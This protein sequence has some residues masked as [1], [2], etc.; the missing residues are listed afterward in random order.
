MTKRIYGAVVRRSTDDGFWAEVPDL[1][2]CFG[3]GATFMEAVESVR[4]GI[5]THLAALAEHQLDIPEATEV[6]AA[7]GKVVYLLVEPFPSL[8]EP[9]VSAAEAARRLGVSPARVSQ[10]IKAGKLAARRSP[11]G[12]LVALASVEEY[13]RSPRLA[14]RPK[15]PAP[16][17]RKEP[18]LKA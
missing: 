14:G 3:Q 10:L 4:D 6:D 12:T 17:N 5:E 16:A 1:P 2:G 9:A 7:D 8:G 11:E 15:R 18:A 13:A